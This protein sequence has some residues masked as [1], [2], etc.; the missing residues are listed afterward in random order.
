M[1]NNTK[2]PSQTIQETSAQ[3]SVSL[4]AAQTEQ[5]FKHSVLIVSVVINL[6][7]FTGWLALQVTNAY[8]AQVAGML[9]R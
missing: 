6:F 1:K 4:A 5:D 3:N 8:D 9:F 2:T 7:I